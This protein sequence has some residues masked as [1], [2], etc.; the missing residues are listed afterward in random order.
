MTKLVKLSKIDHSQ[1]EQ[2]KNFI[3]VGTE[4][5]GEFVKE[6]TVGE[7]FYVGRKFRTSAVK[8]IVSA[9]VFKTHN[10]IYKWEI[11]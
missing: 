6:P 8:E 4:K 11:V 7:H 9:Q 3:E 2:H 1:N 5:I 10:S